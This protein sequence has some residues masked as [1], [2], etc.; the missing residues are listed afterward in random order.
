MPLWSCIGNHETYEAAE[1]G[2]FAW[3]SIFEF[4]VNG[5]CGGVASGTERYYSWN[6][7]NIHFIA[8]DSM[9][10]SRAADGPM[11]QWL[12]ADLQANLQPWIIALWHHPPY[13]KGSHDSDFEEELV[14]MRENIL[15]ILE[16]HG[17][18]LV[19]CGHS[20]CYERSWLLDGYCGDS[21]LFSPA[22]LLNDGDGRENGDGAYRE[23]ASP[24]G[25]PPG[26]RLCR[27]RIQRQCLRGHF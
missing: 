2:K 13:T 1:D 21:S 6:H 5:E 4:P 11:A 22:Y 10:S 17:V 8:L 24:G 23:T 26:S 9:T 19:L 12:T 25:S 3:D 16:S 27:G 18:D 7:A 15:P 14:E 20:H